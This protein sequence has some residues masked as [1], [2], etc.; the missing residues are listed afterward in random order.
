MYEKQYKKRLLKLY[1]M[2]IEFCSENVFVKI[3]YEIIGAF[4]I[5]IYDA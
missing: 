4:P 1:I 5:F 3:H 2:H